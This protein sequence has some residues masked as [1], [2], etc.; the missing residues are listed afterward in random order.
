MGHA[1]F[2]AMALLLGFAIC[3]SIVGI[4]APVSYNQQATWTLWQAWYNGNSMDP[5]KVAGG[6]ALDTPRVCSILALV[7]AVASA[8]CVGLRLRE[9]ASIWT[10]ASLLALIGLSIACAVTCSNFQ[11]CVITNLNGVNPLGALWNPPGPA[12][13]AYIVCASIGFV[14]LLSLGLHACY[15]SMEEQEKK[16]EEQRNQ[17]TLLKQQALQARRAAEIQQH[18]LQQQLSTKSIP[19]GEL[20]SAKQQQQQQG[21]RQSSGRDESHRDHHQ[22]HRH[23]NEY[24]N[25]QRSRPSDDV[26]LP[27]RE[28][29]DS[30]EGL[31][32]PRLSS[33][34]L[35]QPGRSS[36]RDD[37]AAPDPYA[38]PMPSYDVGPY[39]PAPTSDPGRRASRLQEL[40]ELPSSPDHSPRSQQYGRDR[41][42]VGDG[43]KR[44]PSFGASGRG[45]S[46]PR[47]NE[48]LDDPFAPYAPQV[49]QRYDRQQR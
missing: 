42:Y 45:G 28:D 32:P 1:F 38:P 36:R 24:D 4:I 14:C 34:Q 16:E 15:A 41:E 11:S 6:C 23:R 21:R 12:M 13:I 9:F 18:Q 25:N 47:T 30:D 8:L 35:T 7:M 39:G 40:L 10:A 26:L 22:H 31:P 48:D 20:F 5:N 2:F 29:D 19:L 33:R 37:F 3:A 44:Q 46:S 49:Q 17:Q 43:Q 27:L